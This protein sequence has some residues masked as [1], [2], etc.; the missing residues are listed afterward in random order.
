MPKITTDRQEFCIYKPE[1][2]QTLDKAATIKPWLAAWLAFDCIFG[3][4]RNEICKLKRE[5]IW[6]QDGYL[7]TRF[8]VGKKRSRTSTIDQS[9]YTKKITL[10]HYAVPYILKYLETLQVET[11]YIFPWSKPR[12]NSLVIHTKFINRDGEEE[13][14]EYTYPVAQGYRSPQNVYNWVK[15]ANPNIW[16]HLGRHTVAT[17]ASEDGATEYDIQNILD[18][19]PRTASHYVHHGTKLTE[20]WSDK[21]E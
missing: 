20:R 13:T 18:V 11:G 1:W 14:K 17:R 8:F 3:K 21:T 6:T 16:P 10:K 2:Q 7:Y 5:N 12:K 4:R 19:S 9:P 15:K